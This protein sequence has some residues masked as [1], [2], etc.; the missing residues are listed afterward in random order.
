VI[1]GDGN[2]FD[3]EVR[4]DAAKCTNIRIEGFRQNRHC[5]DWRKWDVIPDKTEIV[6]R[7]AGV[8]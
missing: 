5:I 8:E 4:F 1:S 2:G 7:V 3:M 6:S